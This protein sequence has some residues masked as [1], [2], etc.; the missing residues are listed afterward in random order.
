MLRSLTLATPFTAPSEPGAEPPAN[1]LPP[2]VAA[3]LAPLLAQGHALYAVLDGAA[4][5]NLRMAIEGMG[6][7]HGSLLQGGK[8]AELAEVAPLLVRLSPPDRLTRMIFA[9]RGVPIPLWGRNAASLIVS[10]AG[11]EALRAQLRRLT[12]L[13]TETG[14]WHYFRFYVP[15][16]LHGLRP[17]LMHDA[18][19]ARGFAGTAI[20]A[21]LYQPPLR[22][23]LMMLRFPEQARGPAPMSTERLRRAAARWVPV[24]QIAQLDADIAALLRKEDPGLHAQLEALPRARRFGLSKDLW[25]LGIRDTR[26]AAALVSITLM[27][28]L[29]LLREPAFFYATRNPFL[30]G[31]AKAR[32]LITAYQMMSA[33]NEED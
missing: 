21:V 4:V 17:L 6:V 1:E 22:N 9:S 31:R 30:S 14:A 32:Q 10:D 19:M 2:A 20:A 15:S 18:E 3:A 7:E 13:Q 33:R 27:T 16:V 26:E 25:R 23:H 28:G 29:D 8:D 24:I 12:M 11:F 5:P